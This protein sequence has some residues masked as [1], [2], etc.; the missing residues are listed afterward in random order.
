[1]PDVAHAVRALR[2]KI[3]E[4]HAGCLAVAEAARAAAAGP[5]TRPPTDALNALM[6]GK[7]MQ[8]ASNRA[9]AAV[10]AAVARRDAL[11][12][13]L[14]EAELDVVTLTAA[15]Q[16]GG[17]LS[18]AAERQRKVPRPAPAVANIRDIPLGS[19]YVEREREGEE[20]ERRAVRIDATASQ[21]QPRTGEDGCLQ[22]W[23]RGLISA[24]Q[25]W[26]RGCKAHVVY[27][28]I[29]L[30][31]TEHGFGI[32]AEVRERLAGE[33]LRDAETTYMCVVVTQM[34]CL[35]CIY[36]PQNAQFFSPPAVSPPA[37]RL[38]RALPNRPMQ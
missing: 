18:T 1:L 9:E 34:C 32:E 21:L 33:Q 36:E 22:H 27:M 6:A 29:A 4:K 38:R 24:V 37:R 23:H 13:Q 20:Q 19:G 26:A 35:N 2:L 31:S 12:V 25:S 14:A 10:K 16:S 8:Q 17:R 15:A 30:V 11:S 5:A 28:L 7:K 3:V